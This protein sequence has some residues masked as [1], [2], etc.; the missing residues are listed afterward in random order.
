[1]KQKSKKKK[2]RGDSQ[3]PAPPDLRAVID[4]GST[5][6]RMVVAEIAKGVVVKSLESLQQNVSIGHDTF[7]TGVI[8]DSTIEQCVEVM[9]SFSEILRQYNIIDSHAIRAVA[10][11]AVREARNRE[12]FIDRIFIATGIDVRAIDG[13]EVNRLTYFSI[14]PLFKKFPSFRKGNL[15]VVEVG[16]GSRS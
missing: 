16:G 7:T 4:I 15:L 10:T 1:M 11:S 14:L 8:S 9:R 12:T 3:T 5:S 6:I 13:T 2:R